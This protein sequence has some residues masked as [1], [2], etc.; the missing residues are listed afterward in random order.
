MKVK[1]YLGCLIVGGIMILSGCGKAAEEVSVD[2]DNCILVQAP[3][4]CTI[5]DL[6]DFKQKRQIALLNWGD[7]PGDSKVYTVGELEGGDSIIW[8]TDSAF[9]YLPGEAKE[10][11]IVHYKNRLQDEPIS[12]KEFSDQSNKG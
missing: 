7:S 5:E 10:T 6:F 3:E 4:G 1:Y 8:Q 11:N 12:Y 9:I 2:S